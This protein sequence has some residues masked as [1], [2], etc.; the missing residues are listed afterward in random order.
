MFYVGFE[1]KFI[2]KVVLNKVNDELVVNENI[3]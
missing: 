1:R 2:W 3:E